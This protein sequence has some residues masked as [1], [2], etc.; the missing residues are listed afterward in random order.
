MLL[1]AALLLFV[2]YVR[3]VVCQQ[4]ECLYFEKPAINHHCKAVQDT[5]TLYMDGPAGMCGLKKTAAKQGEMQRRQQ[6]S[7]SSGSGG[8]SSDWLQGCF[9]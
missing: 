5:C 8:S 7:S 1:G 3:V 2:P 4:M 9:A 6:V